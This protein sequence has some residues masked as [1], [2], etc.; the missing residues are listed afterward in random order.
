MTEQ[1]HFKYSPQKGIKKKTN[2]KIEDQGEKQAK[3][4]ESLHF[5]L[6]LEKLKI[7]F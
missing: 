6:N 2:K 1:D 5:S 4:L 7:Y 3:T